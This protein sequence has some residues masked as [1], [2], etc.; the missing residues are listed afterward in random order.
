MEETNFQE[1]K[2]FY[3]NEYEEISNFTEGRLAY[4]GLIA[5]SIIMIP[6]LVSNSE[7]NPTSQSSLLAFAISLPLLIF[8]FAFSRILFKIPKGLLPK[9]SFTFLIIISILFA[10]VGQL[11]TLVGIFLAIYNTYQI[12]AIL[13]LVSAGVCYLTFYIFKDLISDSIRKQNK[14]HR[15]KSSQEQN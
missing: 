9:P 15:Q 8:S 14:L 2:N 1:I 6:V 3:L 5:I 13:F 4:T 11:G 12:A 7:H 10:A